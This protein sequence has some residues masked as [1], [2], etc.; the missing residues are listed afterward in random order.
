M[1]VECIPK[2]PNDLEG[3]HDGPMGKLGRSSKL[4]DCTFNGVL[5]TPSIPRLKS[6]E[7]V[8]LGQWQTWE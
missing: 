4:T 3:Q 6:R 7:R 1:V 5:H 8:V 2:S